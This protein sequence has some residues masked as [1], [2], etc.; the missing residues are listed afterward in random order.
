MKIGFS[1]GS[2]AKGNFFAALDIL[3]Y[4]SANVIEISALRDFELAPLI[5]AFDDLH[6]NQYEAVSLH[7]PSKLGAFSE[8]AMVKLLR[9]MADNGIP[10]VVHPNIINN[11]SL[12]KPIG[13]FLYIENMDMRN[14]VGR[15]TEDLEEIFY[16]LP[17]A[18][19]CFDIAHARQVDPTMVEAMDM[20]RAFGKRIKQLHVSVVNSKSIHEPLSIEAIIDYRKITKY[21]DKDTP[22]IL[23]SP[24]GGD[25][26]GMEM[27]MASLIFDD[28][29]FDFVLD[30]LGIRIHPRTGFLQKIGTE[31]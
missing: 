25:A 13:S 28:R 5:D 21:I 9:K 8:T 18:S 11:M 1:T 29:K 2:L 27:E 30:E 10:I 12:W 15:T 31:A 22:I 24:I 26:I 20:V 14:P 6:L 16:N 23:E 4:S 3:T 19:F 7:A 17:D